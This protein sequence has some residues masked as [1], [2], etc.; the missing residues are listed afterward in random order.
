MNLFFFTSDWLQYETYLEYIKGLPIIQ[1]PET[2]GMHPNADIT[3]EQKETQTLFDNILK[4][5]VSLLAVL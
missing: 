1:T 3:K 5:Q 2:F 4:T